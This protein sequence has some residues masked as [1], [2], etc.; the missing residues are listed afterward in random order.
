MP[1][2]KAVPVI[3]ACL[4]FGVAVEDGAD[5]AM[6]DGRLTVDEKTVD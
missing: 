3:V 5:D 1:T 2:R 6:I 4:E